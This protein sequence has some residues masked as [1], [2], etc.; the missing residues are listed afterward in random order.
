[1]Q[2]ERLAPLLELEGEGAAEREPALTP[3][4]YTCLAMPQYSRAA[5]SPLARL[6]VILILLGAIALAFVFF[7]AFLALAALSAIVAPVAL[8]WQ[9]RKL[10]KQGPEVVD[11][12]FTLLEE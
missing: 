3:S 5:D 4:A 1:M 11:A 12:E 10:R 9:R 2:G 7:T 6:G 8:W